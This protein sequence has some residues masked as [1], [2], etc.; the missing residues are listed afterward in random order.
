MKG[1]RSFSLLFK[2]EV[3]PVLQ[4][5]FIVYC[6]VSGLFAD[7]CDVPQTRGAW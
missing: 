6:N 3:K 5:R 7:C 1:G 2:S 4:L